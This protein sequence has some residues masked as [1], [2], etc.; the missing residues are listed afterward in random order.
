MNNKYP[1][2]SPID[3]KAYEWHINR[4]LK[5]MGELDTDKSYADIGINNKKIE[6]IKQ[7]TCIFVVQINSVDFNFAKLSGQFDVIFCFELLEHLQNPLWFM[8]QLKSI[9]NDN[10][11]IYLTMPN[12]LIWSPYHF[13]EMSPRHF[14]KWILIPLDLKIVKYKRLKAPVIFRFGIRPLIRFLLNSTYIYKIKTK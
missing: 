10:G 2:K 5:F 11:M 3:K 9:L 7:K 12:N 13:F 14:S 1:G 6:Y 8:K 4:M